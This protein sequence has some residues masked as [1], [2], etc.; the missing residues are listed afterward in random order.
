METSKET[1]TLKRD[2]K[3]ITCTLVGG[4]TK[5]MK[6]G[7]VKQVKTEYEKVKERIRDVRAEA[8]DNV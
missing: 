2:G 5:E 4:N 8:V 6:E 3:T 1:L 7:L